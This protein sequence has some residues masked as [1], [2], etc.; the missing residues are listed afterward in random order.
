MPPEIIIYRA[1][2]IPIGGNRPMSYFGQTSVTDADMRA[3]MPPS[4]RNRALNRRRNQHYRNAVEG[5]SLFYQAIRDSSAQFGW[6]IVMAIR[7]C[8]NALGE[9]N[10]DIRKCADYAEA[11]HIEHCE[12]RKRGYNMAWPGRGHVTIDRNCVPLFDL[13][14]YYQGCVFERIA[15]A[16]P[17]RT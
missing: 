16:A 17:A 13:P 8:P 11:W 15:A 5:G 14:D 3:V 10:W 2:H 1:T 9:E 7:Q 6:T 12:T 4:P